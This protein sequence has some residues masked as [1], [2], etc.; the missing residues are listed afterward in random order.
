MNLPILYHYWRSSCSWRLRWALELKA[1]PHEKQAVNLLKNEQNSKEYLQLAPGGLVPAWRTEQG[2]MVESMAIL[3]W[4]E[5]TYPT[6]ALLPKNPWEK[7]QVRAL[8]QIVVSG[9]Q[10]LTNL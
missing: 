7:A 1:V 6:P 5:E 3:E 4:L 2:A 9:I 8:C 10:P